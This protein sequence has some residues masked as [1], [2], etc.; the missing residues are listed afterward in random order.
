MLLAASLA[1]SGAR[2]LTSAS[3]RC[4]QSHRVLSPKTHNINCHFDNAKYKQLRLRAFY[5]VPKM[6]VIPSTASLRKRKLMSA[7]ESTGPAPQVTR[8]SWL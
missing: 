4:V 7:L 8:V 3:P 2:H 6:V 1:A 5:A